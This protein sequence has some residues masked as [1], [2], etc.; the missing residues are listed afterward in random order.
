MSDGTDSAGGE[1]GGTGDGGGRAPRA[2][3][4]GMPD[5][6]LGRERH[7]PR[8]STVAQG[9]PVVAVVGYPNVGKSTL[10]NRLTGRR[11][12]VVD[13][14]PG[15]TRDR[16][17]GGAE[18]NGV[19]FQ[20]LDTGGIDDADESTMAR[21]ISAQAVRAIDEADLILFVVDAAVGATPG[22]LEVAERLRRSHRPVIV[23]ANKC[24]NAESEMRAQDLWGLGLG[25]VVTVSALHGRNIGD[26]LDLLVESLPEVEPPDESIARLPAFC[27]MGRPNVGKS[28]IL[29]ALLGEDRMIVQDLPGTT[30]DPVDTIIE[31]DG[32][33]IVLIDTAGLR[34]RGRMRERVEVFSQQR[35][36][37]SAERSDVAIVVADAT[38][39]ITE[40]DLAAC[41]Q[42]AQNHCATL[43]VLNKWDLAQP[44]LTDL[45]G[46]VRRK[47]RQHPPIVA[48]SAVTGEGIDRII[49]QAMK[50]YAK[51]CTR[52]STHELNEALRTLAE[53]RPGPRKGKRRLSMRFLVQ[54]G[55]APPVFRLEVNDRSLMTRDYGFWLENRLRDRFDLAG[56]PVD[57]EVRSRR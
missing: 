34:R 31:W 56:V 40:A 19:Q 25:E 10:F 11:E 22:D 4:P 5:R 16:R 42:A 50:L 14:K 39:G 54:T 1:G 27:I 38:E 37:E 30:R 49:P 17:Q 24:D 36:L 20:V 53:E 12:A 32:Q 6:P 45:A 21:D 23:V 33:E 47:S 7:A 29:N 43:L 18:W 55:V 3:R 9:Q 28:S 52:L 57:I 44:D 51:S 15:A 8:G 46:R 2:S 26:F 48:C 41:D 35:A 13:S